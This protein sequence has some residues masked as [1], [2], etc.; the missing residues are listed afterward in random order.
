MIKR[1]RFIKTDTKKGINVSKWLSKSSVFVLLRIDT[2]VFLENL[3]EVWYIAK[4][5]LEGNLSDWQICFEKQ[6]TRI[7]DSKFEQNFNK[8]FLCNVFKIST[9]RSGS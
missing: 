6:L 3:I 8:G 9:E 2:F 4:A 1:I 7:L 5:T